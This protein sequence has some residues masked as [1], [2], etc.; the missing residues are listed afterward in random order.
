MYKD[1]EETEWLIFDT[2]RLFFCIFCGTSARADWLGQK[3]SF[4][5]PAPILC[6]CRY[7]FATLT[8]VYNVLLTDFV[9]KSG[10][11]CCFWSAECIETQARTS[12]NV[13]TWVLISLSVHWWS[14]IDNVVYCNIINS[15]EATF[16][17]LERAKFTGATLVPMFTN[18]T[19]DLYTQNKQ[20]K[21][22]HAKCNLK[23]NNAKKWVW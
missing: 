23:L 10:F 9:K 11:E 12:N 16:L 3:R 20:S 1:R 18:V 5:T 4:F 19:L 21:T 15:I 17:E 22:F 6:A 2:V 8:R 13:K 7:S 14:F